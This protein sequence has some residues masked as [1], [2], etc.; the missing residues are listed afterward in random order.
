[1]RNEA[2]FTLIEVIVALTVIAIGLLGLSFVF[3]LSTRE[4]GEAGVDVEALELCQAKIEDLHMLGFDDPL[5]DS[6]VQHAD[7]LNPIDGIYVRTWEV[8]DDVPIQGCKQVE[9]TCAWDSYGSGEMV[10]TTIIASAG[11]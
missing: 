1:M 4:I 3:P 7:S 8:Y 5:L 11:R 9:V 6:G 2:G 10:V